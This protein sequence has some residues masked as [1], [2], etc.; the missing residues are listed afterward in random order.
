MDLIEPGT[1]VASYAEPRSLLN[2]LQDHWP[3]DEADG[4]ANDYHGGLTLTDNNTVTST[5]GNFG[6]A[7]QFTAA[8]SEYFSLDDRRLDVDGGS[9]TFALWLKLD[10]TSVFGRTLLC[11]NNSGAREYLLN[12]DGAS[13]LN[14]VTGDG[15]ATTATTISTGTWYFVVGGYDAGNALAFIQLNDEAMV[16]AAV[17]TP[18]AAEA[19]EFRL[20]RD[21]DLAV[22]EYWDGAIQSVG[23]WRR[24]LSE[25][26]I[27]RLYNNGAGLPYPFR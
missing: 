19:V 1:D 22:S 27:A 18:A 11:K 16:T 2:G 9:F 21:K 7:R 13:A 17:A 14:F 4:D 6:T 23:F 3:L 12:V 24:V 10:S 8:N 5:D 26:D 25:G 15:T 20:G